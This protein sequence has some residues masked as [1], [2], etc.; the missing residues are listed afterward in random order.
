[1]LYEVITGHPEVDVG[2]LH[3]SARD[4]RLLAVEVATDRPELYFADEQA[5][6]EQMALDRP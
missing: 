3:F 6:A 2:S 4:G 1:M 5:R